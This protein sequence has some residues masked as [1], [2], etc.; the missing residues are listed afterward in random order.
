MQFLK[1]ILKNITVA[2]LTLEA[3]LI[4]RKY[5]PRV[6]A[7][8]GTVGK[9]SAKDAVY[10]V[11]SHFYTTRKSE[12]SFNSGIGVPLT[13]IGCPN[14][15]NN[16]LGWL[17]NILDGFSLLVQRKSYP[18][19]L[20]LEVG[21]D[22]PGDIK[23]TASWIKPDIAI[24]TRLS[25]VPAHVEFFESPQAVK[26][27]KGE[28]AQEV[29][30]EGTLI[31]NADDEDVMSLKETTKARTE[32]YGFSKEATL[33]ASYENIEYGKDKNDGFP[34]GI[35]FRVDSKHASIPVHLSGGFGMNHIYAALSAL[36]VADVCELNMVRAA[37][38]LHTYEMAPGRLRLIRG[39]KDS[40]IIDDTY[41]AS[42][43]AMESALDT[44]S[45]LESKGRKIAVLGDMLE[46][47]KHASDEHRR[48][49]EIAGK[50]CKM[51]IT[52]G[53]RARH[54]AEGALIAGL[55]E[56]NIFQFEDSREAGKF[57]EQKIKA[58]DIAL[59]KG[60]QGMRM[61]RTVLEVMAEPEK[62][63]ELLVRQ[64]E[65]WGRR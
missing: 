49:G 27:E 58:G 48:M 40:I 65:E 32:S 2:I 1:T 5:K 61:E 13:V 37:E 14:A 51:V 45:K 17:H 41:N 3:R 19:W 56:K 31:L 54:I 20:V 42:P 38:A 30:S 46:L 64:E 8:T 62:K 18:E 50:V 15:W 16:P 52:V 59:I 4:L 9:T 24:I 23:K 33:I 44:L 29:S 28:L 63:R 25:K 7:I 57:L 53:I 55:S 34:L 39:V 47:G 11:L 36:A 35:T 10:A 21:A 60:S 22:R 12:K 26:A 43:V 6:V